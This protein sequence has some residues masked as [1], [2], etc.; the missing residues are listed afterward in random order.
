MDKRLAAICLMAATVTSMATA[1]TAADE[2]PAR[3]RLEREIVAADARLFAGLNAR[4]IGPLK[5]G[6]SP[7]LEFYHDR[8]GVTGYAENIAIFERNFRAPNRV[9]RE[10]L[11]G[12]V[13]VFPAGPDHAMH[14]GKHRF[15][16]R[17]SPAAPE[18]C[19][20]YRFAMVW[21]RDGGQWR[22][23][24]VLSYDH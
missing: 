6:F 11:P 4:D 15:C 10:A 16:N 17:P 2:D 19:S 5:E 18:A 1:A 22:L 8:S 7:R 12:T 14:I 9:R 20:V 21:E 13:E 3:A 23:L 24:R